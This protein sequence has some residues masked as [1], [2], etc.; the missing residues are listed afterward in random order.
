M[1][2]ARRMARRR[3]VAGAAITASAVS[4]ARTNRA[5]RHNIENQNAAVATAPADEQTQVVADPSATNTTDLEAQLTQLKD[6]ET[7]GLISAEDYEAKK[8]ALLGL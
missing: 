5:V 3:M 6:M 2:M 1:P 4:S 7:K 8:N